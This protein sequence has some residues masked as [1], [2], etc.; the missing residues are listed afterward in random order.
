MS[1]RCHLND[2]WSQGIAAGAVAV[3]LIHMAFHMEK[4]LPTQTSEISFHSLYDHYYSIGLII[5]E[6]NLIEARD[7][8][9]YL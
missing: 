6:G 2:I 1:F 3:L 9:T 7:G 4:K 5:R 8:Y